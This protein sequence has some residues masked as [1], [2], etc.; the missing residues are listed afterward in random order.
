MQ[1]FFFLELLLSVLV[2]GNPKQRAQLT[3]PEQ[4]S[5]KHT[6][7]PQLPQKALLCLPCASPI[8][9]TRLPPLPPPSSLPVANPAGCSPRAPL[10]CPKEL[11]SPV[12]ACLVW[13]LCRVPPT[14]PC[15]ASCCPNLGFLSFGSGMGA[16]GRERYLLGR[17]EWGALSTWEYILGNFYCAL[18]ELMAHSTC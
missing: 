7:A 17:R 2:R 11:L 8:E 9:Q 12:P 14:L 16:M 6:P 5:C 4:P 15:L 13:A 3:V 18:R 10:S 1:E